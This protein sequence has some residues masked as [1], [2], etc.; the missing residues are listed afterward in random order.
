MAGTAVSPTR[1]SPLIRQA[2]ALRPLRR[3]RLGD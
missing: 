1:D 3:L 2:A